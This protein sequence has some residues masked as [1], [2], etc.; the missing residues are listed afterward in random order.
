MREGEP[1]NPAVREAD[2]EARGEA[3]ARWQTLLKQL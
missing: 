1:E 3:W 2:K